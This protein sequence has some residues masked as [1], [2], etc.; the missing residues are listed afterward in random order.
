MN[1]KKTSLGLAS[2]VLL[3]G[4]S[5]VNAQ[6]SYSDEFIQTELK[7]VVSDPENFVTISVD[8]PVN[9]VYRFLME[10]LDIYTKDAETVTFNTRDEGNIQASV[11]TER[12]TTMKK[13]GTLVQRFLI[14]EPPTTYAYFT[15]ISKSTL[16]VPLKYSL[17]KYEFVEVGVKKT[18]VK[19]SVVYEPSSRLT[20]FI[21]RRLF[22]SAFKRDFNNAAKI[23]NERYLKDSTGEP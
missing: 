10:R 14:V 5:V 22:N 6:S 15:D 12:T 2:F 19:I 17:A 7:R 9:Y 11:G 23:M 16:S 4:A 1:L 3:W 20:G 18:T 8:A 21:V 13:G